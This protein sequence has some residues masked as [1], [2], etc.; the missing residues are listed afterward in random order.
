MMFLVGSLFSLVGILIPFIN[1]EKSERAEKE[2]IGN[3]VLG[4]GSMMFIVSGIIAIT[5]VSWGWIL[6]MI[7]VIE[8]IMIGIKLIS[9]LRW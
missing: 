5:I 4:L 3:S 7:G 9:A 8:L 2:S 6:V 1:S